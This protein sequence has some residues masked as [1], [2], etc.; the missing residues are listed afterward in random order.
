MSCV[1]SCVMCN[2]MIVHCVVK[3]LGFSGYFV[4]CHVLCVFMLCTVCCV[5][6]LWASCVMSCI[7][8]CVVFC[9]LLC[10]VL[11]RH[12]IWQLQVVRLGNC[13]LYH[14][15]CDESSLCVVISLGMYCVM[16][17]CMMSCVI[18]LCD[19]SCIT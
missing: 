16:C 19:V 7:V 8:W 3:S 5:W 2:V 18:V 15:L 11:F 17:R 1:V 9:V 14:V 12:V 13:V 10:H 6:Q 4:L